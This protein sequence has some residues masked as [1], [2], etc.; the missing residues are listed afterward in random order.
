MQ[1][2][3]MAIEVG[4]HGRKDDVLSKDTYKGRGHKHALGCSI[5]YT[6]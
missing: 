5:M 1:W 4:K 6:H 2:C 3:V